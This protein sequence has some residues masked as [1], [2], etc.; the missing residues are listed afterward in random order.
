[1][2]KTT[3]F[4]ACCIGLM[5]FASCKKDPVAPTINLLAEVGCVTEDAQVYSGDEFL[6]GF[7]G[8]GE[9]LT[10]IEIVLSLDGTIVA[11]HTDN[12]GSQKSDP[13]KP[14]TYKHAFTVEA[15]GTVTVRGTVTD[16]NGT[17]ASKT[18]EIH[19]NEKPCAKF[20]G[21]YEGE[22]LFT[23][24]MKAEIQGMDPMEQEVTDRAIPVVLDLSE[25]ATITEIISTCKI[26]DQEMEVKGTVEGNTVTFD[27]A[28]TTITFDYPVGGFSVS[29]EV[30]MTYNVKAT[31]DGEQLNL[32]GTCVGNGDINLFIYN[33]TVAIDGTIG[34][35]LEKMQ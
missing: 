29:P 24:M 3:L 18:F 17:T 35:S 9:N 10:Q 13:V 19:F 31:L 4:L 25:G 27:A 22:A 34:G 21:H 8:T 15:V 30:N 7:T 23:G 6:I 16:A 11:S 14:F 12:L 5:F 2:K 28:N 33:G 1:M 26:D 20:L 32:D